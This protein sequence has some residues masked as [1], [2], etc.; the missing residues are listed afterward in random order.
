MQPYNESLI[1]PCLSIDIS[2]CVRRSVAP[3]FCLKVSGV[4][5][6]VGTQIGLGYVSGDREA[7]QAA[8]HWDDDKSVK[9]R[10]GVSNPVCPSSGFKLVVTVRGMAV[11]MSALAHKRTNRRGLKFTFVRFGPIADKH[12]WD[13]LLSANSGRS[14]LEPSKD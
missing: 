14:P 10:M 8:Y 7:Y 5:D 4:F 1:I 12:R 6:F 3:T 11:S 13:C 9:G 2:V